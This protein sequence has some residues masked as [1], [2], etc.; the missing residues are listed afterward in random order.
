MNFLIF[1][2]YP[3]KSKKT[4]LK[5]VNSPVFFKFPQKKELNHC[6]NS[7]WLKRQNSICS[8]KSRLS[9]FYR[10]RMARA[11]RKFPS[12]HSYLPDYPWINRVPE[13]YLLYPLQASEARA[14]Q[15]TNW[16]PP[17]WQWH[18]QASNR[19]HYWHYCYCRSAAKPY[20][21]NYR[22]KRTAYCRLFAY[23]FASEWSAGRTAYETDT[24]L[25]PFTPAGVKPLALL[26]WLL[27][28]ERSQ[29]L[30]C[31]LSP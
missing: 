20:N 12:T 23:L 26:A 3:N 1:N 2:F 11:G 4:E 18:R 30:W 28:P 29:T 6:F 9:L 22:P 13:I 27:L 15:R 17:D 7:S 5:P 14:A 24:L 31:E 16:K 25:P 10:C 21:A 8:V 19:R